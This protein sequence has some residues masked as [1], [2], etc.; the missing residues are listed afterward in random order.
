MSQR[1]PSPLVE[2]F[3]RALATGT[4]IVGVVCMDV[5]FTHLVW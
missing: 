4:V 2:W 5:M 3:E 1:R